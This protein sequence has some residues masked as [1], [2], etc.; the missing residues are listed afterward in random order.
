MKE[1]VV[2]FVLMSIFRGGKPVKNQQSSEAEDDQL[3]QVSVSQHFGC[4]PYFSHALHSD[5]LCEGD[6]VYN[7]TIAKVQLAHAC[8]P[9]PTI[10]VYLGH[11]GVSSV[12]LFKNS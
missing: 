8:S 6:I 10:C 2:H 3:T 7:C 9:N 4:F 11:E 12:K 1:K 5:I